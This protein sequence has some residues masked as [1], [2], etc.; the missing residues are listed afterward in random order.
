[1]RLV[2]NHTR[3]L[4]HGRLAALSLSLA[5]LCKRAALRNYALFLQAAT[6]PSGLLDQLSPHAALRAAAQARRRVPAYRSL[7]G[8][9]GWRDDPRLSP[10]ERLGRLPVTDKENYIKAFSTEER[11]LDGRIP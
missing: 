10:T 8:R 9:S 2:P 3:F 6:V 5:D 11:C 4:S 1:M 7:L